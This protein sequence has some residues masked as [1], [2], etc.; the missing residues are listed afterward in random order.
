MAKKLSESSQPVRL[1]SMSSEDIRSRKLTA[2]ER[3]TLQ[4]IGANQAAGRE[5]QSSLRLIPP[6]TGEQLAAMVRLRE[7]RPRKQAVSVR[8]DESVVAWLK[9]K[10]KGHL[11]LINDIVA[12]MMEAERRVGSR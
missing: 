2:R 7:A 3:R 9:S 11:T 4:R 10:G 8:L 1:K 5:S 6:L 12:N